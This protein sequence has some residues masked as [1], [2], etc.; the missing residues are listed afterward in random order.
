MVPLITVDKASVDIAGRRLLNDVSFKANG[1]E[2]LGLIG[3]NGAGKSTLL[4]AVSGDVP[5]ATGRIE[6]AGHDAAGPSA[7]LAR[8]RAVMLQD[9]SVSFS[10]LVRDVVEMGRRPWKGTPQ[11]AE[12]EDVVEAALLAAELRQLEERDVMTLSGGERA[13]TAI[14][15]V[16]AQRT[17][18]VLLDEPTAALDIRHQERVLSLMREVA[19]AGAA[20][21]V[22]LHDL[23]LAASYCDRVVCLSEG[24]VAAVG[25]VD[26]VFVGP[27]LSE[28]YDWPIEVVESADGELNVRPQRAGHGGGPGL[29]RVLAHLLR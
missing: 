26:E 28:V 16:L 15:R 9:V 2:V 25:D 11:E 5:L 18:V 20:V 17:P 10:F 24:A 19:R 23:N 1:G 6:V 29:D 27:V 13:R 8:Q 4:A 7:L 22:V 12:D 14:A 3:P 21:V